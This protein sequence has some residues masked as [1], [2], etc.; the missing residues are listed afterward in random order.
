MVRVP[1][2]Q[3]QPGGDLA[4]RLVPGEHGLL[5][6]D[7]DLLLGHQVVEGE[8]EAPVEVALARQ[9]PVVDVRALAVLRPLEPPGSQRQGK[10]RVRIP[11]HAALFPFLHILT[12]P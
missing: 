10:V 8:D 6:R 1:D 9:R 7:D 5:A 2:L 12:V 3:L 4:L 11:A